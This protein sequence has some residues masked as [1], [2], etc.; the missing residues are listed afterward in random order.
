MC[1]LSEDPEEAAP[2]ANAVAETYRAYQGNLLQSVPPPVSSPFKAELMSRASTARRPERLQTLLGVARDA[3]GAILL[4]VTAGSL[5]ALVG[6]RRKSPESADVLPSVFMIVFSVVVGVS[7]LKSSANLAVATADGLLLAFVVGG[8]ADWFLF[9]RKKYPETPNTFPAVFMIVFLSVVGLGVLHAVFSTK[10]YCSTA[11]LRLRPA[12]PDRAGL[13]TAPGGYAAYDPQLIKTQGDVIRS[14]D[15]LRPVIEDL[16]LNRQWGA[17]YSDGTPL[18]T[19]WTLASLKR[20]IEVR[21]VP[22]TC[23]IE[24]RAVSEKAEEAAKLANSLAKTY[25]GYLSDR[26]VASAQET[27]AIQADVL[28]H[29]VPAASPMR[30]HELA[31]LVSY[32]LMGLCLAFAAGGGA[33]WVA[34]ELVK[35]DRRKLLG[36]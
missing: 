19:S 13:G 35:A 24:I 32:A 21:R 23:L 10:W 25:R 26:L 29:G 5:V 17:R 16:D 27:T 22:D 3:L 31:Q 30:H 2:I 20:R 11:R 6:F 14:E 28:D 18:Q 15:T 36:P 4:G 8:V 34:S 33:L 12:T 1:V 7:A 9:L